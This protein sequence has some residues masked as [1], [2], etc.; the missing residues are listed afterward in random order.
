M[1][2]RKLK[3]KYID[4]NKVFTMVVPAGDDTNMLL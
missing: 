1:F 3:M 4:D 2:V